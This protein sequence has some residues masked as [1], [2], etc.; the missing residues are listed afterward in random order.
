V[1]FTE[2]DDPLDY[3]IMK[4]LLMRTGLPLNVCWQ[5]TYKPLPE[6]SCFKKYW[7]I[8]ECTFRIWFQCSNIKKL[9]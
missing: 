5:G 4:S 8:L 1:T 3:K 2:A 7:D 9:H 6:L